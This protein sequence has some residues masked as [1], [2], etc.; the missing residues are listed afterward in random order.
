MDEKNNSAE[1]P[2]SAEPE[3]S[4]ANE[5]QTMA[6]NMVGILRSAWERPE[7]R[8]LQEEIESGLSDFGNVLRREAKAISDN[9]VSQKVKTEVE[10]LGERV[11]SGQVETKVREELVNALRLIN[12][13]LE[14]VSTIV[15]A[16]PGAAD[17]AADEG[18][19]AGK[20]E[21]DS[22]QEPQSDQAA[23]YPSPAQEG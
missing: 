5:F 20:G 6:K 8:K 14:K 10:D 22:H 11:R 9:P 21:P 17:S 23:D 15:S 18:E 4:I 1:S 13:E 2:D 12:T 3:E 19:T 16:S 7:R